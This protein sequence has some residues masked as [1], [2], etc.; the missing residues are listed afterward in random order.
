MLE[1]EGEIDVRGNRKVLFT[2]YRGYFYLLLA[3]AVLDVLS[4]MI[5]MLLLGVE[6][7]H[8]LIVRMFSAQ[9]G[10][11]WG[12]IVG[13]VFQILAVWGFSVITPRLTKF[14]CTVVILVNLFAFLF[15]L[16][17][18]FSAIFKAAEMVQ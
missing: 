16:W 2:Q 3:T 6:Q 12:P 5:F 8:N 4:T 13:K 7:E 1:G 14:V 18:T 10:I 9:L 11:L 17:V 15:N